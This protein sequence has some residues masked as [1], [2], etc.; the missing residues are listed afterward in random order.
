MLDAVCR[1]GVGDVDIVDEG[2]VR[3]LH[4]FDKGCV[5]ISANVWRWL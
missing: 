2:V 5:A 4:N 3:C 1:G